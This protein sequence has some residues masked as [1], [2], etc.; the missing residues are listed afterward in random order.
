MNLILKSCP[1]VILL[2]DSQISPI[3]INALNKDYGIVPYLYATYRPHHI[4]GTLK[5][6]F[7]R[8]K[9]PKNLYYMLHTLTDFNSKEN[10]RYTTILFPVSKPYETFVEAHKNDLE[11]SFIIQSTKVLINS[12]PTIASKKELCFESF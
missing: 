8:L 3:I 7:F 1:F 12:L 4:P 6:K 10:N 2:G 5:Y 9:Y 11:T